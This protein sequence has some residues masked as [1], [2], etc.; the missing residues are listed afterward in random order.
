M[1]INDLYSL[2]CDNLTSALAKSIQPPELKYI[3]T[4]AGPSHSA[5]FHVIS[6]DLTILVANLQ[7]V[8]SMKLQC[9]WRQI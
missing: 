7:Q 2:P 6:H 5:V 1:L 9:N 3:V 4:A 8:P